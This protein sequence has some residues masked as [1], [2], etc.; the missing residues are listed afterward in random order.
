MIFKGRR[1][2]IYCRISK[3]SEK[4]GK[5]VARQEETC[6]ELAEHLGYDV[7]YVY[8]DNDISASSKSHKSRPAYDE[9]L[10]AIQTRSI[11][12]VICWDTDRLHRRPAEL[13]HYIGV[14]GVDPGV[15]THTVN[16]GDIDLATSSGRMVARIKGAVAAA[17]SEKMS[18]RIRAQKQE[19]RVK[20]RPMG[21]PVPLGWI[22]GEDAGTFLPDPTTAPLIAK[23]T[24]HVARGE[25]LVKVTRWLEDQGMR[26]R[27]RDY[28]RPADGNDPRSWDEHGPIMSVNTV[29][30]MLLRPAN[31]GLQ[32]HDG[33]TYPGL[34]PA[35]VDADDY[36]SCAAALKAKRGKAPGGG[37]RKHLLSGVAHCWCGAHMIGVN[38]D[39]YAC[40]SQKRQA[41]RT[42][43][44]HA[45]KRVK[46]LDGYVREVV[47]AYLGSTDVASAV[48]DEARKRRKR[49]T[50]NADAV[51]ATLADL[52][53]R[54]RTLARLFAAGTIGEGQ[55]VEGTADLDA[56]IRGVEVE[57]TVG[58]G[59]RAVSRIL[60]APSP[61][62]AF[63]GAPMDQQ[64]AVISELFRVDIERGDGKGG[65]RF[66]TEEIIIEP[67][68]VAS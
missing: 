3:D 50:V 42:A 68:A 39:Q 28:Q 62:E 26:G 30:T 1:A 2:G 48:L 32:E 21:G 25:S 7:A 56:Q 63:L 12:A 64:R 15:P 38:P 53:E 4:T 49:A 24:Q 47:A 60:R 16:A 33:R 17:E 54:K 41:G 9:L 58:S 18:E 35:I 22:K 51:R 11:E 43:P 55:L 20:G 6:R 44:G 19:A 61:R 36:A 57:L 45:H 14:C 8:V 5:G 31:V 23:A 59:S 27:R 10:A 67:K 65:R 29:R 46:P 34:Y 40:S 13:E 37:R 52:E 66:R